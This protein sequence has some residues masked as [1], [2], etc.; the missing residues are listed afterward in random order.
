MNPLHFPAEIVGSRETDVDGNDAWINKKALIAALAQ[1]RARTE[2]AAVRLTPPP[3]AS[4]AS[5]AAAASSTM[6][7][8]G[9]EVLCSDIFP[10]IEDET[11]DEDETHHIN[12][13]TKKRRM[14]VIRAR[15]PLELDKC[16]RARTEQINVLSR[17]KRSDRAITV[18][19][20]IYDAPQLRL[21]A[22]GLT[23]LFTISS[24]PLCFPDE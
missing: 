12:E 14:V 9:K 15:T 4:P 21:L 5:V 6:A 22:R 20:R 18:R 2:A 17:A 24:H 1:A 3:S 16:L 23:L 11:N 8:L 13:K 7:G 19:S 10:G